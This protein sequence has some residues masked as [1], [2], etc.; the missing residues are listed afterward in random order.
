MAKSYKLQIFNW[1]GKF[2]IEGRPICDVP[3]DEKI[4]SSEEAA[5]KIMAKAILA[6]S[7][8]HSKDKVETACKEIPRLT[9]TKEGN[10]I[11]QTMTCSTTTVTRKGVKKPVF[12]QEVFITEDV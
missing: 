8:K 12:V 9:T 6:V 1:D 7:S 4:L 10:I 2:E 5:V 11:F 3:V